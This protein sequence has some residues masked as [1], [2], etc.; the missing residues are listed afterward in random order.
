MMDYLM[1]KCP[2]DYMYRSITTWLCDELSLMN[3]ETYNMPYSSKYAIE[4]FCTKTV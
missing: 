3:K 1:M 4:S 2:A